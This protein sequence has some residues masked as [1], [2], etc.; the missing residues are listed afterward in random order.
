[1]EFSHQGIFFLPFNVAPTITTVS[2]STTSVKLPTSPLV[3]RRLVKI[4]N[5]GSNE[6]F[7]HFETVTS[8]SYAYR[9]FEGQS[10]EWLH[11]GTD[12]DLY[13][14]RSTGTQNVEVIEF[15]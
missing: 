5:Q 6:L 13:G 8:T 1:M 10:T 15:K 7:I 4:T 12:I 9:L 2:V 11:M 14:I 3:G